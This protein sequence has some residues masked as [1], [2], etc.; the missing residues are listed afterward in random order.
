MNRIPYLSDICLP[1]E[2]CVQLN[3]THPSALAWVYNPFKHTPEWELTPV[4]AT[5]QDGQRPAY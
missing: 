3:N 2:E 5:C 1:F 4:E